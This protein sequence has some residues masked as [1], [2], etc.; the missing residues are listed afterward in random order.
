MEQEAEEEQKITEFIELKEITGGKT[1]MNIAG[2][3]K[4]IKIKGG[5]HTLKITSPVDTLSLFGGYRE[6]NIKSTIDNLIIKGGVSKINIHNFTNTQ[7]KNLDIIGGT[8]EINIY[9]FVDKLTIK[10]GVSTVICNWEH[11][12]INK[13][14]TIGGQRDIYLNPNTQKAIMENEGGTF[15]IHKTEI[16]PEPSWY[17]ESISDNEIP[18]TIL[19]KGVKEPCVICL[20]NLNSGDKVYFLPCI[21]CFHISCLQEWVKKSKTCP[22]CKY[23]LKNKLSYQ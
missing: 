23:E 18:I 2:T 1:N 4:E 21:H 8:H 15:N 17:Q 6:L 11:S 3:A 20:N 12:K 10:G 13:I 5:T 19:T 9:S 14:E 22:N 7:V 16:I